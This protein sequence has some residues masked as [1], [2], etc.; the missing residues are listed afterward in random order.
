MFRTAQLRGDATEYIIKKWLTLDKS[1]VKYA[2]GL[3]NLSSFTINHHKDLYSSFQL[4]HIKNSTI[5]HLVSQKREIDK[6]K[7]SIGEIHDETIKSM[8]ARFGMILFENVKEHTFFFRF[9]LLFFLFR[10]IAIVFSYAFVRKVDRYLEWMNKRERD[11]SKY[12]ENL[13]ISN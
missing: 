5:E 9:K 7:I 13:Y 4:T 6:T 2:L 8:Y 1:D 3:I 12:G 11:F 10:V